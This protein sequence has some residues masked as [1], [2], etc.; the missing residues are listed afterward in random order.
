MAGDGIVVLSPTREDA[1]GKTGRG[2]SVRVG[3]RAPPGD[4]ASAQE[5][6]LKMELKGGGRT[7][8]VREH[9]AEMFDGLPQRIDLPAG[10]RGLF[11]AEPGAQIIQ[12]PVQ[13]AP[14]PIH[15]FQRERQ[16]QLLRSGLEGKAGQHVQQPGPHQG[17]GE[18]VPRQHFRQDE[19]KGSSA[20]ATLPAIGTKHPLPADGLATGSGGIVA[21]ENAVPVQRFGLAA[22]GAALLLEGKSSESSACQSRTK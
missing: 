1:P 14:Q 10:G 15:R 16:P 8:L 21:A 18:G 6:P 9:G 2:N 13:L 7:G 19:G 4:G 20:T 3:R 5:R 11:A 12:S 22:A 17:S